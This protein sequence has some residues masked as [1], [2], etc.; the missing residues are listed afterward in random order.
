[1]LEIIPEKYITYIIYLSPVVI[2]LVIYLIKRLLGVKVL[3]TVEFVFALFIF[4][5][6]YRAVPE[7]DLWP[8]VAVLLFINFL[9]VIAT[10]KGAKVGG[11]LGTATTWLMIWAIFGPAGLIIGIVGSVIIFVS[12]VVNSLPNRSTAQDPYELIPPN[13][14][15]NPSP[16]L[17]NNG[18]ENNDV[19]SVR[20]SMNNSR[21][22]KNDPYETDDDNRSDSNSEIPK[23]LKDIFTWP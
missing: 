17:G 20:E 4:A 1:M 9:L 16:P 8:T 6:G 22:D 18:Y 11:A 5:I 23:W 19:D 7:S 21:D 10:Y 2:V 14:Q 3:A 15:S 12:M 13:S